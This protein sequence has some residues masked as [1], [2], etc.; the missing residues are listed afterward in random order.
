MAKKQTKAAT[1][2]P[3]MLAPAMSAECKKYVASPA[4]A[5][6]LQNHGYK[7][8]DTVEYAGNTYGHDQIAAMVGQAY[9]RHFEEYASGP[10]RKNG[11]PR[12][13]RAFRHACWKDVATSFHLSWYTIAFGVLVTI[14]LGPLGLVCAIAYCLFE[15]YLAHDL[16]MDAATFAIPE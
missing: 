7:L 13:W 16:N 12:N 2:A 5:A 14:L 10:R 3:A 9:E 15:M 4:Y 8:T 6:K 1:R 11:I